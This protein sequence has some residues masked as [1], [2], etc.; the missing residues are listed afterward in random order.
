MITQPATCIQAWGHLGMR[1]AISQQD[2]SKDQKCFCSDHC[3]GHLPEE[4]MSSL[5]ITVMHLPLPDAVPQLS[6]EA[7]ASLF[8]SP[9]CI[10]MESTCPLTDEGKSRSVVGCRLATGGAQRRAPNERN[11][12][13]PESLL[14]YNHCKTRIGACAP[15]DPS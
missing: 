10:P 11:S 5:L 7:H 8:T 6:E 13:S 2:S 4:A 3:L 14:S 15:R 9:S 12:C 1:P